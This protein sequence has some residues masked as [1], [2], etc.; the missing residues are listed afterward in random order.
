[1]K[2]I[3]ACMW[4]CIACLL[5]LIGLAPFVMLGLVIKFLFF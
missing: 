4:L 1:M 5:L 3:D 2:L